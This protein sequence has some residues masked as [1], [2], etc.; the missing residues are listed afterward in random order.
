VEILA[1]AQ[2]NII[3]HNGNDKQTIDMTI[4]DSEHLYLTVNG[5]KFASK[6]EAEASITNVKEI[7]PEKTEKSYMLWFYNSLGW[8]NVY[9]YLEDAEGK[10]VFGNEPG[11]RMHRQGESDWYFVN[12]TT[13]PNFTVKFSDGGSAATGI[14]TVADQENVYFT[15]EGQ[16][17]SREAVLETVEVPAEPVEDAPV[18]NEPAE[19]ESGRGGM[20]IGIGAVLA[21]AIAAGAVILNKKRGKKTAA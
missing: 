11:I 17:A 9:V 16:F 18:Q 21:A 6:E 14:F 2:L 3:F 1:G 15:A 10:V 8:E 13:D 12:V 19:E 7:N 5:E 20:V 4:D